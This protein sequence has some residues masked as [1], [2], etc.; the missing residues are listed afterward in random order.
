MI[1]YLMT[2][3]LISSFFYYQNKKYLLKSKI[4]NYPFSDD[5]IVLNAKC[6]LT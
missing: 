3:T 4:K 6:F 5:S 1:S 2:N